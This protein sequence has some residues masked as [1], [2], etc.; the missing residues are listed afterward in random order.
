MGLT[1]AL[2][3]VGACYQYAI[4]VAVDMPKAFELFHK[5]ASKGNLRAIDHL[6]S[7]YERGEGVE[8]NQQL[9]DEWNAQYLELRAPRARLGSA[10]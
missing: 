6:R 9:A 4:G 8:Q 7:C 5:G 1:Q 2:I 3:E 10:N